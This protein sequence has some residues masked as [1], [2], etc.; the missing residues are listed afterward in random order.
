ML[1]GRECVTC[2]IMRARLLHDLWADTFPPSFYK[3]FPP[4]LVVC[5]TA[6]A[7]MAWFRAGLQTCIPT[8]SSMS[9]IICVFLCP[10]KISGLKMDGDRKGFYLCSTKHSFLC[11]ISCKD[12]WGWSL[13][14]VKLLYMNAKGNSKPQ[15]WCFLLKQCWG[16]DRNG[17]PLEY[18]CLSAMALFWYSHWS[19]LHPPHLGCFSWKSCL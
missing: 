13:F 3:W 8:A 18:Q 1:G 6:S 9:L 15:W 7:S 12:I 14:M 5:L 11:S 10:R 16:T 17:N 19:H 2:V 4:W